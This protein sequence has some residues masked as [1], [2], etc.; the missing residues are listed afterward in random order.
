MVPIMF[1][2]LVKLPD[3]V[4]QAATISARCKFV[5]HAAAPVPPPIKRAMIEWWGPVINEYYGSTEASIVV[6]LCTAEEWLAHPGTVGQ[7]IMPDTDLRIIDPDGATLPQ[8]EPG[9][10]V[11]PQPLHHYRLHLSSRRRQAPA[12]QQGGFVRARRHRLSRQ[13]MASCTCATAAKDMMIS[14]GVNIYPAEIEAELH[15]DARCRRLR[16]VRHPRRGVS[17]RRCAP[18]CSRQPAVTLDAGH[19]RAYLREHDGGHKVPR[20]VE[21][22]TDLPREDSG[23]IFKRKLRDPYWENA[24]AAD[25][26]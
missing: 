21:F 18:W 26:R 23:K 24:G 11:S 10:V 19:V 2:R 17:G 6:T 1:N 14:G 22:A 5:I 7:P 25:L 20:R 16:R 12:I 9:E 3:E 8:G 4:Q 15:E 13:P